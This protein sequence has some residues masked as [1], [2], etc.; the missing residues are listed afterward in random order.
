MVFRIHE[1][2]GVSFSYIECVGMAT[3]SP[4]GCSP[5]LVMRGGG[6]SNLLVSKV[7][8]SYSGDEWLGW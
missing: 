5:N 1:F 8:L 7:G 2:R 6:V 3:V 4:S